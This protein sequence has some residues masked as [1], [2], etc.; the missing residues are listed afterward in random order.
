[1]KRLIYLASALMMFSLTACNNEIGDEYRYPPE[2]T[3]FTQSHRVFINKDKGEQQDEIPAG[4]PIVFKGT[5]N[6]KYGPVE[7]YVRYAVCPPERQEELK[8]GPYDLNDPSTQW[9]EYWSTA[10]FSYPSTDAG[11]LCVIPAPVEHET[12]TVTMPG[13]PSGSVVML[14]FGVHTPYVESFGGYTVYTVA[15]GK[16]DNGNDENDGNDGNDEN[17]GGD[18]AGE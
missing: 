18:E 10:S 2:V 6:S 9:K 5:V 15:G 7:A 8:L 3:D 17:A 4:E 1:M 13:Q 12:F 14:I 16:E 11:T